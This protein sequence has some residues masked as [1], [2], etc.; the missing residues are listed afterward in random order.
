MKEFHEHAQTVN[1]FVL[2]AVMQS[3]AILD[4]LRRE[5]DR[6]ADGATVTT[7]E[8]KALLPEVLKRDVLEGESAKQAQ[9]RVKKASGKKLRRARKKKRKPRAP[10]RA[11]TGQKTKVT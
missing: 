11:G 1:R 8:I 4:D 5:V 7:D 6:S 2:A 3:D 10:S 9:R